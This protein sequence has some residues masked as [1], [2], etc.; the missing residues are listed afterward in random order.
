MSQSS[1]GL[2]LGVAAEQPGDRPGLE[3]EADV[4]EGELAAVAAGQPGHPDRWRHILGPHHVVPPYVGGGGGSLAAVAAGQPGHRDRWRHI[5]VP[6]HV[7]PPYVWVDSRISA[8]RS[9]AL[10]PSRLASAT[11]GSTKRSA[12]RLRRSSSSRWRAPA[13]TNIPMPRRFSTS[14]SSVSM[15]IPLAAVAGLIR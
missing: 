3:V 14:P 1:N 5:L 11:S 9:S 12:N 15:L 2:A 8:T 6:H 10:I 13:A 7:V 4:V